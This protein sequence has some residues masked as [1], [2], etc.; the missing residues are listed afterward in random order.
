MGS[1]PLS[2]GMAFLMG[3]PPRRDHAFSSSY[4]LLQS[5]RG[6]L[7]RCIRRCAS[8]FLARQVYLV[9][10]VYPIL[11]THHQATSIIQETT[12][13]AALAKQKQVFPRDTLKCPQIQQRRQNRQVPQ[14]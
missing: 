13:A 12:Q 2:V 7:L 3:F 5:E 10:P 1:V 8:L 4:S 9:L 6:T 11:E 14:P